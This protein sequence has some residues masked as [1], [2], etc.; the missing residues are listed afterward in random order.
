MNGRTLRLLS[1]G[2]LWTAAIQATVQD[3][4]AQPGRLRTPTNRLPDF[5]R[6]SFSKSDADGFVTVRGRAAAVAPDSSVYVQCLETGTLS[7]TPADAEGRFLLRV[8]AADGST[9]VVNYGADWISRWKDGGPALEVTAHPPV[10]ESPERIPF[11]LGGTDGQGTGYWIGVGEQ[12]GIRFQPGS[13]LTYDIRFTYYMSEEVGRADLS[14][15][16][17]PQ[18][19]L[20]RFSDAEGRVVQASHTPTLMTPTGLPIFS[21]GG[22]ERLRTNLRPV[23]ESLRREG[24]RI[25]VHCRYRLPIEDRPSLPAGHYFGRVHWGPSQLWRGG[26]GPTPRNDENDVH[27]F[28]Q[29]GTAQSVLPIFRIGNAKPPRI[30]WILLANTLSNG[31]RGAVAREQKGKYAF[32]DK[33]LFHADKL[34]VAKEDPQTGRPISYR[35]EPFLPT[36]GY[37]V[38]G[39]DRPVP[40]LVKFLFPSGSL[41]VTV[42]KPDGS[43]D[44]LGTRPFRCARAKMPGLEHALFGSISIRNVYQLTT[45]DPAFEYEFADYGHYVVQ[46]R[47]SIRDPR[48]LE[49]TG[50]GTYDVY[51]ARPLDLD[52]GTVLSTPLQQGDTM[53]AVVHTHPAVPADVEVDVRLHV[54]SDADRPIRTLVRGKANRY[55]YF[56]PGDDADRLLMSGPGEYVV[57]VS[58]SYTDPDGVLWMGSLRGASVVEGP[59]PK[60]T[61]H[62]RRG[63]GP[64]F[65]ELGS[66]PL[67]Y[68]ARKIDPP[69]ISGEERGEN[70]QMFLPYMSGDV[71]W[72][73]DDTNSGIFPVITCDDPQN[74]TRWKSDPQLQQAGAMGELPLR[75]PQVSDKQL[76]AV[77]YPELID[78]WAYYYVSV[79]R[80]GVTVRSFVGSG[81]VGRAYWGFGDVY[82][83][84]LGNGREGDLPGDVKLQYGGAVYRNLSRNVNE[85]AIYGS[86]TA[87]ISRGTR[88]GQRVFPP[89]QGAA[90]GPNGGPL[91]VLD[92]KNIDMF[93]T[94]TGTMPGSILEVG[95]TFSFSGAVWPTLPSSVRWTV[96]TPSGRTIEHRGRANKIGHYYEPQ[97]DFVVDE[98]GIYRVRVRLEHDGMTSAGPVEPPLPS[99]SVLGAEDDTYCCYVV[100]RG[101]DFPLDVDTPPQSVRLAT[102]AGRNPGR[103]LSIRVSPPGALSDVKVHVTAQLTGTVLESRDLPQRD[104]QYIYTYDPYRLGQVFTNLD[105]SPIDTVTISLAAV[106]TDPSGRKVAC[107]RRILIQGRDV[108]APL[109]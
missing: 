70:L 87:M 94:P 43:V 76:P 38:G 49:Y 66:S 96:V 103:G 93:L 42:Q 19:T 84:Q 95:D 46:M 57:D 8:P 71:Q 101:S 86:M 99:G 21:R 13:E 90:G 16:L 78:T 5:D 74:V 105:R 59:R 75:L 80:P 41:H 63:L 67:W 65:K 33:V 15:L 68:V 26:S 88:L 60:L 3:A 24:N 34:I 109:P 62:G 27:A 79:Q 82:N 106:G 37:A 107:A 97:D 64:A 45:L 55:G 29:G 50:G 28:L 89:F 58:A 9:F 54:N 31:T 85:Y 48:G 77:Q 51:V 7:H 92:G 2:L 32:A 12:N 102:D 108:F 44:D 72:A 98:P 1:V 91:L 53:S 83:W 81:N 40:P 14:R 35:L 6:L 100:S 22:Y 52:L 104:G 69:G 47:G 18:V 4:A 73:A 23:V 25:E 10:P 30:P 11:S 56:C 17:P 39:P 36:I 61:A 20:S